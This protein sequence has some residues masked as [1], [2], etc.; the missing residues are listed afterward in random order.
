MLQ[1]IKKM[2]GGLT[3]ID[4]RSIRRPDR[5]AAIKATFGDWEAKEV[6]DEIPT[7]TAA[8]DFY[9]EYTYEGNNGLILHLPDTAQ[10]VYTN[11]ASIFSYLRTCLGRMIDSHALEGKRVKMNAFYDMMSAM[12]SRLRSEGYDNEIPANA[13]AAERKF[14]AYGVGDYATIVSKKYGSK[15]GYKLTADAKDWIIAHY[16]SN[17]NR[18]T[19]EQLYEAYNE[20][21]ATIP[22]WKTIDRVN[23]LRDFLNSPEIMPKWYAGRYGSLKAKEKFTRQHRTLLPTMRDS[24]WYGDGT[25]INLYY[26]DEKGTMCTT[27]VYEVIDVYSEVLL[28]YHISPTEN[29]EAQRAA[30][31]MALQTSGHIPYQI[32]YDNQ[33]G[34]K[35]EDATALFSQ[36]AHLH[37]ATQPYNGRSK[38]IE[39]VFGRFQ[40]Q[41]LHELWGFTG[42]N[43]TAKKEESR[44]NMEFILANK[45]NLPTY[46]EMCAAYIAARE[47]WNAGKH[48]QTGV[49]RMEMYENSV[50]EQSPALSFA[51]M[52]KIFGSLSKTAIEYRSNGIQMV[53]ERR[54]YEWEV[55]K[56]GAPDMRFYDENIGRRFTIGFDPDDMTRIC[57][58]TKTKGGNLRFVAEAAKFIKIHRGKQ[59]QD[60]LDDYMIKTIDAGN[61]EKR[62]KWQEESEERLRRHNLHPE[63]HGLN[64]PKSKGLN[65]GKV[66]DIGNYT[67]ELSNITEDD[68]RNRY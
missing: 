66:K 50:N 21:A 52:M 48:F 62:K 19:M 33:G 58:Y 14:K 56:D 2:R 6:N 26:R 68:I 12:G 23:T 40:S 54:K 67:K 44:A 37:I 51:G 53:F 24:L 15:N 41:L 64:M 28:G 22:G 61:K 1:L 47:R 17:I 57:L 42:M 3:L 18:M 65:M 27:Q 29:Y 55:L 8:A 59:E 45:A 63:Q 34:H 11:T 16:E 9:K 20:K 35:R 38:T 36:L 46:S 5:V 43:I 4:V 13:K 49:E 7:D 31:K 39:S 10:Q 60:E 30:Y 25:K 32:T